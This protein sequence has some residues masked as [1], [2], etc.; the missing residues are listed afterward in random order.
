[1]NSDITRIP[2][3]SIIKMLPRA[4]HYKNDIVLLSGIGSPVGFKYPFKLDGAFIGVLKKGH[5]IVNINL[6]QY[7]IRAGEMFFC[8]PGDILQYVSGEVE[9]GSSLALSMDFLLGLN[10]S[11]K[12]RDLITNMIV[13]NDA[14]II[15]LPDAAMREITSLFQL[16][17]NNVTTHSSYQR[18]ILK[19]LCVSY[20]YIIAKIFGECVEHLPV[21]RDAVS[22]RN[23]EVFLRFMELLDQFHQKERSVA[24]YADQLF[25]TPKYLSSMVKKVSGE[26]AS[27][28]INRYVILEAKSLLM[29]SDKSIQ[30]IAYALNFPNPS[31]FGK[32]FKHYAGMTPG[33]Y[34]EL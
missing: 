26:S 8:S 22:Q 25:V 13:T 23:K 30:E 15:S 21:K 19:S 3:G 34:K 9:D 7:E 2:F 32:Y 10:L 12:L 31:F 20:I 14:P 28:W 24:F 27:E 33:E 18:D 11:L 1:M 6:Q 16:I 29:H 5:L 4:L 17:A